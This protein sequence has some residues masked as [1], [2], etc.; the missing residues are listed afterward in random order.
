MAVKELY[1]TKTNNSR[2]TL[3][4]FELNPTQKILFL[5]LS[6]IGVLLLPFM[7]AGDIFINLFQAI[8]VSLPAYLANPEYYHE[9]YLF[10]NFSPFIT[11]IIIYS[12][13]FCLSFYTLKKLLKTTD[14]KNTQKKNI[15]HQDRTVNWLGFKISHGQSLFLFIVS[16]TSMLFI[17]QNYIY[18]YTPVFMFDVLESLSIIPMGPNQATYNGL[19]LT[20]IPI[21]INV[22]FFTLCLYSI[23]ASRRGKP[24]LIEDKIVKNKGLTLFII[25]FIIFLL[26][27]IRVLSH[28]LLF[29]DL[30]YTLGSTPRVT[31]SYQANDL[32][33]TIVVLTISLILM[34]SSYFIRENSHEVIRK[35][36]KLSWLKIELT[37]HRALI[38]LSIAILYTLFFT[39]FYLTNIFLLGVGG[40]TSLTYASLVFHGPFVGIIIFCY[41]PIGKISK[42]HRLLEIVENVK[43]YKKYETNW[44]KFKLNRLYSVIFLSVSCGLIPLYIFQLM[45]MNLS[46]Q[47]TFSQP[48]PFDSYQLL[49]YPLI[50]VVIIAIL[51]INI[52][53]IKKTIHSIKFQE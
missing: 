40:F 19:L 16:L 1:E 24:R 25:F 9:D 7:L 36:K 18:S 8:F 20:N 49:S 22:I 17:V 28:A 32:F 23:V 39:I 2:I 21:A 38:L 51:S 10:Y 30:A 27:F 14:N 45:I 34:I 26:S 47:S 29:T 33:L 37:P 42:D 15:I 12:I 3:Y 13:F 43:N 52:Y 35:N 50:T 5:I 53:T 44:F 31:N 11:N 6:L 41:Y 48:T 4:R 46:A